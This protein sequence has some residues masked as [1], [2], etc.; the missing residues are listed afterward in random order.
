MT[1]IFSKLNKD[2]INVIL[3]YNNYF[4]IRNGELVTIIPK[5]DKRYQMLLFLPKITE[6]FEDEFSY[7]YQVSFS[8]SHK[9]IMYHFTDDNSF[10]T[11][12]VKH[13][14]YFNWYM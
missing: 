4:T 10:I 11:K 2:C 6:I 7:G 14:K 9:L 13:C 12:F 1:F 8:S 5:D 3:S